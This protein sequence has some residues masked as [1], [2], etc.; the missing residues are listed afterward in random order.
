MPF[1]TNWLI[2]NSIVRTQLY[3]DVTLDDVRGSFQSCARL[4]G[5]SER[6]PIHFFHDW[7]GMQSYPTSSP[8]LHNIIVPYIT[9]DKYR[10]GWVVAYGNFAQQ[11]V[12]ASVARLFFG[13]L[14]LKLELVNNLTSALNFVQ[15]V[16][17]DLTESVRS[18]QSE[19]D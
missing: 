8:Q 16:D 6:N 11:Q 15:S 1:N 14:N 18:W 10:V 7:Q 3:G 17:P 5:E 9:E 4:L 2:Q 12:L 19:H 13:A